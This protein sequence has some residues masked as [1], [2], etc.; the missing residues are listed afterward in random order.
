MSTVTTDLDDLESRIRQ[1]GLKLVR[2]RGY[3]VK[4]TGSEAVHRRAIAALALEVLD[5]SDLFG[6]QPEQGGSIV[7]Q[8]LLGMIGHSDLLTIENALWQPDIE[9][10]EKFLNGSI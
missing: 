1:A 8:K 9:W 10:L 3:G 7:N 5:E 2:R 4:I 6:R